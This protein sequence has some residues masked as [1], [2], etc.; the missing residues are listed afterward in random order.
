MTAGIMRVSY[1]V[2]TIFGFFMTAF[3]NQPLAKW[4]IVIAIVLIAI[5]SDQ[6]TKWWADTHLASPRY[7]DHSLSYIV[8]D[9][10]V[11]NASDNASKGTEVSLTL[12]AWMAEHFPSMAEDNRQLAMNNFMYVDGVP[13]SPNLVLQNGQTISSRLISQQIIPGYYDHIY[14]RNPGAAWSFLADSDPS[15]RRLFFMITSVIAILLISFFLFQAAW[16]KQRLLVIALAMVLGG[17]IGNLIDRIRFDYVIDFISWH[18]GEHYWPTFNIADAFITVAVA[19]ILIDFV[20]QFLRQNQAEDAPED[21]I[22]EK[23]TAGN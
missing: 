20:Q 3:P 14:A 16:E 2:I 22:E 11:D 6:L 4:F 23:T 18:V 15:F 5:F 12:S 8:D 21:V 1:I 10:S 9:A 17:A 7:P 19:F 13:A